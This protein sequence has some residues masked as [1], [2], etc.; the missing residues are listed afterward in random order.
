MT[1]ALETGL[2][3][4]EIVVATLGV[5]YG[6]GGEEDEGSAG[7]AGRIKANVTLPAAASFIVFVMIYFPCLAAS[8]VFRR[9]AGGWKHWGYLFVFT[10]VTAWTLSF[11]TFMIATAV[12]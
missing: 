2:A 12:T 4:K 9:E 6:L 1:V 3:A 7:L 8:M 11:F 5:L 10:T